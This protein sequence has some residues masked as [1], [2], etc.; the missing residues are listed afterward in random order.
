M[1]MTDNLFDIDG[2]DEEPMPLSDEELAR[3]LDDAPD[4]PSIDFEREYRP[5]RPEKDG[6]R[7][8]ILDPQV[9]EA[10]QGGTFEML[11][12]DDL[13]DLPSPEWLVDKVLPADTFAVIFGAPGS[14]K[15]FWSLD[16]ACSVASGHSLHGSVV[17]Q[18]PVIYAA[19][20][21]LR[22]LKWRLEAWRLA[23]PSAD[24]DALRR[25]LRIVPRAIRLLEEGDAMRV[26]NTARSM[27]D[28][29]LLIIDTW[30][31]ALTGGDENSSR[32]VG[33]A[34]D[35][36]EAVRHAT[37]ATV[38]VV[39]HSNK[40]GSAERGSTALK[41]AADAQMRME[42]DEKTGVVTLH[43]IKMKDSEEF[44]D[45]RFTL[46][47]YGHSAVLI[48]STLPPMP[49]SPGGLFQGGRR[50]GTGEPF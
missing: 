37:G 16:A 22:G 19:G 41:G 29:S 9:Q 23:H 18:G 35:V 28:L 2:L 4:A 45:R 11:T 44:E 10:S 31:R 39:H 47:Q 48:P 15:S 21:G 32:D 34:I 46:S 3:I 13:E 1:T 36:C 7:P 42:K 14:T 27:G 6:Y 33:L 30:A 49:A 25:N 20:E 12:L 50:Y 5:A 38:L 26:F 8:R 40:D 43:C 17:K 24:M